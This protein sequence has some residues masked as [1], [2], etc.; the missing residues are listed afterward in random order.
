MGL[1]YRIFPYIITD[2][3][4]YAVVQNVKTICFLKDKKLIKFLK[5][6]ESEYTLNF[7]YEI[8]NEYM[9]T[10][11]DESLQFLL[12][13]QLIEE[14]KKVDLLYDKLIVTSNDKLI[15][16]S[17]NYNLDGINV[18]YSCHYFENKNLKYKCYEKNTEKPLYIIVL[19]PFNYSEFVKIVEDMKQKNVICRFAFLYNNKFYITNYYKKDW[20]N[21]CPLCFFSQLETS[22]RAK[23]KI[24]SRPTFQTIMDLIYKKS[25]NFNI[26]IK[27][28]NFKC[29]ILIKGLLE[30]IEKLDEVNIKNIKAI[31]INNGYV[32]YDQ[33]LHWELCDCY[34]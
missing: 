30:D 23:S 6:K 16:D 1:N 31:D 34:E 11:T 15:I 27:L 8:L 32:E 22:L 12:E 28:N 5:N 14:I 18:K 10:Q 13:N 3:D 17:M 2:I 24:Y 26:E 25:T 29:L 4:D 20:Y 7:T 9:G 19:N 21:P 33:A